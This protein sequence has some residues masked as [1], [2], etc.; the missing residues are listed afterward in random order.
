MISRDTGS[1]S[2]TTESLR[3]TRAALY[4]TTAAAAVAFPMVGHAATTSVVAPATLTTITVDAA[5]DTLGNVNTATGALGTADETVL[6]NGAVTNVGV[7][8]LNAGYVGVV[9]KGDGAIVEWIAKN[10]KTKPQAWQIAAWSAFQDSRGPNDAE[11]RDYFTG[12]LKK[13]S[14]TR[15]DVVGWF[16]VLD[17]DDYVSFGGKA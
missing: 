17:V 10:S 5:G 9:G 3:R 12:M 15:E 13:L 7:G 4:F 16:D 14:M 8:T 2:T 1:A 6:V 11:T